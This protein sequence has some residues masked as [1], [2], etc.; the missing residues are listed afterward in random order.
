MRTCHLLQLIIDCRACV[1]N[2]ACILT[3][4]CCVFSRNGGG[5]ADDPQSP[6][7]DDPVVLVGEGG[8][9]DVADEVEPGTNAAAGTHAA[10][11]TNAAAGTHEAAGTNAAAGTH[12]AAGTNA[13]AGADA[14]AGTNAA[15]GTHE[16]A[17]TNAAAGTHEAAGTNATAGA[18]AAAGTNAAAGTHEAAGTN[19][20]AG[21]HEAAGTNATAGADAAA[22]TNAAAGTHEAVGTGDTAG[23]YAEDNMEA[24]QLPATPVDVDRDCSKPGVA[25][26]HKDQ[27]VAADQQP[28]PLQCM[29]D[30]NRDGSKDAAAASCSPSDVAA[31]LDNVLECDSH[32]SVAVNHR[33]PG[34]TPSTVGATVQEPL[35]SAGAG[36]KATARA[37]ASTAS[38]DTT[39]KAPGNLRPVA[40]AGL[41]SHLAAVALHGLSMQAQPP[42][43]VKAAPVPPTPAVARVG[44]HADVAATALKGLVTNAPAAAAPVQ[45]SAYTREQR[46]PSET[47]ATPQRRTAT[48]SRGP[49]NAVSNYKSVAAT[50][51]AQGT[52]AQH[53]R[54]PSSR[55]P[56][57]RQ[58]NTVNLARDVPAAYATAALSGLLLPQKGRY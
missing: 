17:G 11:G 8:E 57:N 15:A 12:E 22:G 13:T 42:T 32:Q 20:A 38:R 19:A 46:S 18:D 16:A 10:A 54:M 49:S 56:T 24:P 37:A 7:V 21:T 53:R 36:P 52:T 34:L 48:V 51:P 39:K 9:A 58:H 40:A 2:R 33:C 45:H 41:A 50:R 5:V 29:V 27:A 1:S 28:Q 26:Q 25:K 6:P 31:V 44:R 30:N 35:S 55:V 4:T 3:N 14:A 23:T 47:A 43:V